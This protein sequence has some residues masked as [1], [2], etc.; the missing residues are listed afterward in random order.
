MKISTAVLCA[1]IIMVVAGFAA[2]SAMQGQPSSE[3]G[4]QM[5]KHGGAFTGLLGIGAGVAGTLLY[6]INRFQGAV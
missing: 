5:I 3:T 2:F 4:A 1:G 6:I